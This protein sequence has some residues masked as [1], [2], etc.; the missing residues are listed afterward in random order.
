VVVIV[1]RHSAA[2]PVVFAAITPNVKNGQNFIGR[3]GEAQAKIDQRA[4]RSAPPRGWRN[5]RC[6]PRTLPYRYA[7]ALYARERTIAVSD[8]ARAPLG[9]G[10]R[11]S[12]MRAR[13]I[14][15]WTPSPR[16]WQRHRIPAR[17][18]PQQ[19]RHPVPVPSPT[20][21]ERA[22]TPSTNE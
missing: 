11:K 10:R 4:P 21:R 5:R 6:R 13:G 20:C 9:S 19:I 2:E 1:A 12:N 14:K 17:A 16:S 22:G 18:L 3:S 15:L 7:P 8:G